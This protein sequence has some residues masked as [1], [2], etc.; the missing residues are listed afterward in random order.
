MLKELLGEIE[1]AAYISKA[2][3]AVKM[4]QP[5]ELIED[6]LAQLIRLGYLKED[7]GIPDCESFCKGC[8]YARMCNQVSLT[9]MSVTEK[10]RL[11]LEKIKTPIVP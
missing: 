2:N 5:L 4:G 11:L 7:Q 1:R 6:G 10:G 3:L 9:T 8:P